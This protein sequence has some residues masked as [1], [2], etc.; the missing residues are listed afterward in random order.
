M[1]TNA[2]TNQKPLRLWPGV[3][4]VILLW[5]VRFGLLYLKP[6]TAAV[7]IFGGIILGLFVFIWWLFLSRASWTDRLLAMGLIILALFATSKALDKSIHTSMMGLMFIVYAIPVICLVLVGWAVVTRN[8]S[9]RARRITMAAAIIAGSG[10]WAL[11]RTE[12]MR[13]DAH[14]DFAWRWTKTAEEK[15]LSG[16]DGKLTTNTIDSTALSTKAEWPGFR[17]PNRDGAIHG[18]SIRT[19]WTKNPPVEMWHKSI[20]PACWSFAIHGNLLYTQ[21]QRGEF[22]MVTCYNLKTG[23]SVWIHK[24]STRFWDSHAGAGP[25]STPTLC[26][27]RVYTLGAKGLLNVMS[28]LDG[29]VIWSHDAAADTKVNLPVWGYSSSPLV[30]DSIVFVAIAGQLLAYND[31]NGKLLWSAKDGGESYSSP[32]LIS[33]NGVKQVVFVNKSG[34]TGHNPT[35][36]KIL[37]KLPMSNEPIVQ[38][39]QV[40]ESDILLCQDN[41]GG[42]VGMRRI[43]LQNG[44]N[45]WT[46]KE[47]WKSDQ[48]KPYF[49]DFVIHK[50]HVYGFDGPYL[51]CADTEKGSR[52]WK[53][54][55]YG[56]EMILIADQDLLVILSERGEIALVEAKPEKFN[57]LGKMPAIKGRTWNHPAMAGNVLVVR[58]GQEMA[59]F[60]L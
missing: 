3:V 8:L 49:N 58:N 12:G 43:T 51:V 47:C 7:S 23:N 11:L 17:G 53:G 13:G 44:P 60:K 20:G 54:N 25:R 50:G 36:G 4:L 57:E 24:D 55:R 28:A 29:K 6:E 14:F 52:K 9:L 5:L 48:F 16:S 38:P 26:N 19:D 35:D 27:G 39:A 42:G 59:A 40:S 46:T 18:V 32:H 10:F 2:Q 22:E 45:G 15:L 31:S 21:E 30:V 33:A 1:K 41:E 34:T 56:G 37:W